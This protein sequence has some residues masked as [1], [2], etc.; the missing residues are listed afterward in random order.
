MLTYGDGD[1]HV[2]RW[3]GLC[4]GN[5]FVIF[6]LFITQNSIIFSRFRLILLFAYLPVML[7]GKLLSCDF[8]LVLKPPPMITDSLVFNVLIIDDVFS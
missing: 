7:V 5:V 4:L 8:V 3:I 6:K 2:V 1:C